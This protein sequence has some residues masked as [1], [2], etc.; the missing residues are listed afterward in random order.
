MLKFVNKSEYITMSGAKSIPDNFNG[1]V[2]K[3]S[4]YIN[5]ET[6]GAH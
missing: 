3:A 4:N 1:L 2:I 6:R 5:H